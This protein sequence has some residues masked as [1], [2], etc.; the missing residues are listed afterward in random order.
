LSRRPH[1][2]KDGKE[3]HNEEDFEDW[4][5]YLHGFIYQINV[6]APHSL[7]FPQILTLR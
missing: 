4:I 6:V 2:D 7:S 5:N 1:Q 3:I